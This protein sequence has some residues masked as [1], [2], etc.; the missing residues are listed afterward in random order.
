L[1]NVHGTVHRL[2]CILH[3]QRDA[4]YTK[5]FIIISAL[6]V[7]GGYSAHHQELIIKLYV[8]PWVLACFPAVYRWC[9]LDCSPAHN[10][11]Q[12]ARTHTKYYAAPS[13]H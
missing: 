12:N 1:S 3:N 7:S 9:G 13:P 2:A 11:T 10:F 8:Q 5:L 6:N 4:T